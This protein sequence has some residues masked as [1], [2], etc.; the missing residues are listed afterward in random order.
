MGYGSRFDAQTDTAGRGAKAV[1]ALDFSP[2]TLAEQAAM[3]GFDRTTMPTGGPGY[4]EYFFSHLRGA[5]DIPAANAIKGK[6]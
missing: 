2:T 3:G 5:S 1:P 6:K 4:R